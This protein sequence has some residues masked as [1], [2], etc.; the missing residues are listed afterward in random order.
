MRNRSCPT[1]SRYWRGRRGSHRWRRAFSTRRRVLTASTRRS[2][3]SSSRRST[4]RSSRANE[5][6]RVRI[7]V[8]SPQVPFARGGAE[9]LAERLTH[10][11]R[12]RGHAADLV[13]MPFK[14]YPRETVL[15]HALMWRLADL[16]E[17]DGQKVD[18]VIGTKFPSYVVRHPRKV[19][20]LV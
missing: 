13:T 7:L 11:L 12:E 1:R 14:W 19:V 8:C 15:T 5:L 17:V 4:T 3:R 10:E 6:A 20:W 2:P 9:I 18:L 16:T